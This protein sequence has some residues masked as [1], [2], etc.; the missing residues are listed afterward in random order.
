[1]PCMIRNPNTEPVTLPFP[2]K[3]V[4]N[5]GVGVMLNVTAAQL[6]TVL[7]GSDTYKGGLDITDFPDYAGSFDSFYTEAVDAF[8]TL[9]AANTF[10]GNATFQAIV[11][12]LDDV[13]VDLT[14]ESA[15]PGA[16]QIDKLAGKAAF[17]I[18]AST[19]TV[20]NSYVTA[21]SIVLVVMQFADATLNVIR[22]VVPGAGSFVVTGNTTATAATKFAFLVI[23]PAV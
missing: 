16:V 20:T 9:A 5:R 17:A 19:C 11:N 2:L 3:G 23:N 12:L 7:G 4:L 14:D 10:A 8:P 15:T 13:R 1:M 18:G 6:L 22:T 21:A